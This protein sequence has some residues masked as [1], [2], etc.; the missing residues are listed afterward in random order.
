MLLVEA[1]YTEIAPYKSRPTDPSFDLIM[2]TGGDLHR[3]RHRSDSRRDAPMSCI[4][5][6]ARR[7]TARLRGAPLAWPKPTLPTFS[8]L[9]GK[10]APFRAGIFLAGLG[11]ERLEPMSH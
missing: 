1:A 2:F 3:R 9:H 6:T 4:D 7:H 5:Q 8:T 11:E 10:P